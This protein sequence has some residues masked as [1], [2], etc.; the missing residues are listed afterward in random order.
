MTFTG[1]SLGYC[2][3]VT[4][5]ADLVVLGAGPAGLAAAWRAAGK[6]MSV[7]VLEQAETVGGMAAS[8]E[9]DGV[10]VDRGSHRLHPTAS[11]P[12]LGD[13][14]MLLGDD[15]QLRRRNGR[16]RVADHWVGFPLRPAELVRS[17][18]A[19]LIA[20]AGVEALLAPLRRGAATTYADVLRRGLGPTVY[21]MLYAPYAVKLWGRSGEQI[22]A[23]Q[24]RRRVS[25]DT[26][27]K[28]AARMLRRRPGGSGRMFYYPR[29]GFGQIVEALGEAAVA[30]GVDIRLG[31]RVDEIVPDADGVD[32]RT[33]TAE[34][35]RAGHVFSTV[36]L[37]ILTRLCRPGAPAPAVESPAHLRFRAMVL[38][39]VVHSARPWTPYDAHYLPDPDTPI[40]RISEPLN[41]RDS[42]SDPPDRTVLCCEIPC[43]PGDDIWTRSDDDLTT[44]VVETLADRGLPRLALTGV[45]VERM[46]RVYPIYEVGYRRALEGLDGWAATLPNVTSFGRL[47]LFVHDNTH[48]T[49]AMAYDAVDALGKGGGFDAVAW[50][51]AR[52]RFATH[53]VED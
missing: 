41:Y 17:L 46:P 40:T 20:R 27:W 16:L 29:R 25:A 19:R 5:S 49:M 51:A 38:V 35:V 48:H 37:P 1:S 43:A 6:G 22:D 31:A 8:L 42:T 45:Y 36:P 11:A 53:V 9:V 14:R 26:A 23:E 18:P 24:A 50:A 52:S 32:V 4:T 3:A 13:L 33:A 28:V 7:V 21:D 2:P 30:A 10:R 12:V 47:G 34:Q 15:L 39:Y 44:T